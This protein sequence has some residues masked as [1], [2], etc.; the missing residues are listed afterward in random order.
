MALMRTVNTGFLGNT[1]L[2]NLGRRVGFAGNSPA[3]MPSACRGRRVFGTT[4]RRGAT[5]GVAAGGKNSVICSQGF[6]ARGANLANGPFRREGLRPAASF[7]V[8]HSL[9]SDEKNY[10]P[11]LFRRRPESALQ[12]AKLEP[13]GLIRRNPRG[14]REVFAIR[15]AGA[16][17]RL[18]G[19]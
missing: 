18:R 15:L 16:L 17:A 4:C 8:S 10:R 5:G 2:V 13:H 6:S 1:Q 9:Q 12:I 14:A 3:T 7:V 11:L 19:A